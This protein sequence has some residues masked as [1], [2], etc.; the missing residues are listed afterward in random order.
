MTAK[1]P[2]RVRPARKAV[3][4]VKAVPKRRKPIR[5]RRAPLAPRTV[6]GLRPM[7]GFRVSTGEIEALEVIAQ[8]DGIAVSEVIRRSLHQTLDLPKPEL[9]KREE[10]ISG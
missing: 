8:R 10:L 5:K 7:V 3:K 9:K 4:A 2:K 1:A 6:E